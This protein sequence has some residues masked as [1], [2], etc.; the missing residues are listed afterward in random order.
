M[1]FNLGIDFKL[2]ISKLWYYILHTFEEC[3]NE[4]IEWNRNKTS[5]RCSKCDRHHIGWKIY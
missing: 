1:N 2:D 3:E 5:G 4:D